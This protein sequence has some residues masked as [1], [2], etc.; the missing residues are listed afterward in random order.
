MSYKSPPEIARAGVESATTKAALSWDRA[1]VAGFLAG[2]YIA[3][4]GLL[5]VVASAGMDPKLWGGVQ[6]L[7]TGG[8]FALG[9]ILVVIAGSE[10]LTGNMALVPLAALD[11]RVSIAGLSF[12]LF[13]VLIGNLIGSLFV[14]YFLAKETGVITAPAP[15]ARLGGI[16]TA[17]AHT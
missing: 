5:A 6:T 17:K 14:A 8:V 11:K 7:V 16:S 3:F 1:L 13:W 9:L 10:L 12:N 2:A 15:L 4:A